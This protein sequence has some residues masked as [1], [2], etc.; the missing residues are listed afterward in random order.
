MSVYN[1]ERFVEEAVASIL[2]Q[3]FTDFEFVILEDGSR[4]RTYEILQR[5]AA[6][7]SRIKLYRNDRNIGLC[8][9]LNRGLRA[10]TA[11]ILARMDADDIS[12]P[13]R[14]EMQVAF[15]RDN[16]DIDVVGSYLKILGAE[17]VWALPTKHEDIVSLMLFQNPIYH[18]AVMVRRWRDDGQRGLGEAVTYDTSRRYAQD[19][20]LWVRLGLDHSARFANIPEALLLYRRHSAAVGAAFN[21]ESRNTANEVRQY[22]LT[23]LSLA[24]KQEEIE[25]HASISERRFGEGRDYLARCAA[26]LQKL[27]R[28]NALSGIY[29]RDAFARAIGRMWFEAC[30]QNL[31]RLGLAGTRGL[32]WR[33]RRTKA[34]PTA[35]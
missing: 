15:L 19:Y 30:S 4:D 5:M 7:D 35:C 32:L 28:A 12:R 25:L 34:A 17:D 14:L 29:P 18:P 23:K 8:L 6:L 31:R 9:S 1:G 10:A 11:P 20:D 22:Q 24:P 13:Q 27:E 2:A 26:W 33:E 21:T 16:P 3:T